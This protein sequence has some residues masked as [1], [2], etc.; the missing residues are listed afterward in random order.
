M[1]QFNAE[2]TLTKAKKLRDEKLAQRIALDREIEGLNKTIEGLSAFCELPP[3]E[4]P[5]LTAF[6]QEMLRF[7]G[8]TDA[9]R[10]CLQASRMPLSASDVV[11][12]LNSVSYPMTT[13]ES[14]RMAVN[15]V[16]NRLV[17]AGEA[18]RKVED[19]SVIYSWISRD[20][21]TPDFVARVPNVKLKQKKR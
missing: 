16:L 21:F 4:L 1:D 20:S 12:K 18:Q 19:G 17:T 6:A 15:T 10:M 5:K 7:A 13:L 3:D 14:P 8:L 9:I 2:L 11:A